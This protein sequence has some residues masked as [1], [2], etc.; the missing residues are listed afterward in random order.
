MDTNNAVS[1]SCMSSD[2]GNVATGE[3][4]KE[5]AARLRLQRTSEKPMQQRAMMKP[6]L[7]VTM[8]MLNAAR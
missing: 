7:L 3:G 8:L 1:G 6:A 2:G 4:C 5:Q